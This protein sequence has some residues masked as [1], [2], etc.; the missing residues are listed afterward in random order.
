MRGK[1][2]MQLNQATLIAALQYYFEGCVFKM[3]TF[4]T[5]EGVTQKDDVFVVTINSE[6]AK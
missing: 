2:V 4:G 5:V 6:D 1:N 3:E